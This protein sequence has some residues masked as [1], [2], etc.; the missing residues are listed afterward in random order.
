MLNVRVLPLKKYILKLFI[1]SQK[2]NTSTITS[3]T[4]SY[5][6]LASLQLQITQ[7]F[8]IQM[9]LSRKLTLKT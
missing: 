9:I 5:C 1:F 8:K 2:L 4:D 6:K 3:H 7:N